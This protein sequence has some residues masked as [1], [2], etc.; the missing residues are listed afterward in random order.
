MNIYLIG[1][2]GAGKSD[3][4]R[5][6]AARCGRPFCDMDAELVRRL[7]RS[8]QQ[9]VQTRGWPFFRR[10]ERLLLTELAARE[11]WVVSTGG[12]VVLDEANIEDLRR[13]GRVV[14]LRAA[15]E[16]LLRR[17]QADPLQRMQRPAL[18]PGRD[19][20]DEVRQTL[21]EREALY[22]RAMHGFVDTDH[23]SAEEVCNAIAAQLEMG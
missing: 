15:P 11:G 21:C 19:L 2:R 8:I 7:G 3:V 13:S 17:L 12:G 10:A 20:S 16:T 1:A 6:L 4:G 18:Q 5:R 23:R 9:V 14:W 22:R